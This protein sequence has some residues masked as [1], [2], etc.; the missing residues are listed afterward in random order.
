MKDNY[1]SV[2]TPTFNRAYTLSALYNSLLEQTSKNFEWLI[3]DDGSTDG[4]DTLVKFFI[5]EKKLSI[6]YIY[7]KNE[8]KHI[9]INY[10]ANAAIGEWFFIV[11]S[12]DYLTVNAISII[13]YYCSQIQSNQK[14]AG[15]VGLRGNTNKEIW[16]SNTSQDKNSILLR[17]YIDATVSEYRFKFNIEGDRAEVLRTSLLKKYPFPLF[18][19]ERFIPESLLWYQLAEDGYYFRWFNKVIYITEYLPDGL[20]SNINNIYVNSKCGW[21]HLNNVQMSLKTLPLKERLRSAANYTRFSING[22]YTLTEII[23]NARSK[24][25]F[26][27]CLPIGLILCLRD[28]IREKKSE[29]NT[30]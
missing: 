19:G 24:K 25:L 3:V 5:D 14:Y 16:G 22:K 17:E 12:D 29:S 11:D 4:T 10:G 18:E 8:G 28:K 26:F 21:T 27:S 20:T 23:K 1:I 15:V 9:A 2:F 13:N 30:Y 7:K 6:K